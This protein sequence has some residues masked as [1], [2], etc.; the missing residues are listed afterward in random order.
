MHIYDGYYHEIYNEL[1]DQSR[2]VLKD[3]EKWLE[4][5]L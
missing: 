1:E 4:D 3:L 2:Q 5:H